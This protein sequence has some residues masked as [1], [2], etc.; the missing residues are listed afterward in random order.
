MQNQTL[1][2]GRRKQHRILLDGSVR[3]RSKLYISSTQLRHWKDSLACS[4]KT[5]IPSLR[6]DEKRLS[7]SCHPTTSS[8]DPGPAEVL[9]ERS[10]IIFYRRENRELQNAV[11]FCD[12]QQ[13]NIYFRGVLCASIGQGPH[14]YLAF[15]NAQSPLRKWYPVKTKVV[16][17]SQFIEPPF[18]QAF[19]ALLEP[20]QRRASERRP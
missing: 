4:I 13:M 9:Q 11:V 15:P 10:I 3:C 17:R 16:R 20:R 2:R 14:R 1:S 18:Q 19:G 7:S 5:Q 8:S 6:N 12:N